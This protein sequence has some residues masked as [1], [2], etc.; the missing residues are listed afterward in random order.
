MAVPKRSELL[1][2]YGQK[3]PTFFFSLVY[4]IY[5]FDYNIYWKGMKSILLEHEMLRMYQKPVLNIPVPDVIYN[6]G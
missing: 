6:P 3:Y 1:V 4:F 2:S 5:F